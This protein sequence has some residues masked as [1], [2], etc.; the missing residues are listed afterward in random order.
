MNQEDLKVER[1]KRTQNKSNESSLE[2]R[3]HE[4]ENRLTEL[5]RRNAAFEHERFQLQT[6]VEELQ[7]KLEASLQERPTH[8]ATATADEEPAEQQ[9][10]SDKLQ[11]VRLYCKLKQ[12]RNFDLYGEF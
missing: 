11:F 2:T 10:K 1:E 6:T 4:L 7:K 12:T 5:S 8:A 3:I 9:T